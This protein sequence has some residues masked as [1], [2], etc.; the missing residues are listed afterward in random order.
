LA[1]GLFFLMTN[2][3]KPK[4]LVAMSGGVDSSV[5]AALLKEQG[6]D[7]LGVTMQIWPSKKAF[8]GC[9]SLE[10]V[11][12]AK[13][14]ADVLKIPHYTLNF[15]DIFKEKVIDNFIDE[16]KNGRTPNPCIRC[17]QFIKF[18]HLLKKADELGCDYIA[19]GH[20]VRIVPSPLTPLP[21][22]NKNGYNLLKGKDAKKDQSYVLYMLNQETLRRTLFPMGEFT[23]TEVRQLAKKFNL[24]VHDKEESQ[25]ICFVEDDDYVRFL[26]ENC[27][28]VVK[29]GPIIDMTGKV[30]GRHEG[31]AFY[32][33]GQRKGIGHHM[34]LPKYVLRIDAEKNAVIIGDQAD[35]LAKE[36]VAA[37]LCYVSGQGPI[38]PLKVKAKIR[39]NS[40]EHE[41]VLYPLEG[42]KAKVVFQQPQRSI[43]PGQSVVFYQGG[44]VL[45]GGVIN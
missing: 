6:H 38:E 12:D 23:K 36:L 16:Y 8:G 28:A 43:T 27:P 34:S 35:L 22:G 31:I 26:K 21:E 7:V 10:A 9:C 14:V 24:A 37:D 2:Q 39:Y 11:N 5:T 42:N 45:G 15:R 1:A 18:D 20:Y 13:S 33:L 29:P 25:E 44:E 3:N 4:I 41:A 30:V 32:T 17:N 40:V 19:T